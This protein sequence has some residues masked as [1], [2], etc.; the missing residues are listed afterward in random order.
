MKLRK[1]ILIPGL[2]YVSIILTLL[3][4]IIFL[5]DAGRMVIISL[6]TV[7][8]IAIIFGLVYFFFGIFFPLQKIKQKVTALAEAEVISEDNSKSSHEFKEIENAL[9]VHLSRLKEFVQI[10]SNLADGWIEDEFEVKGS[11]DELGNALLKLKESIIK[12]NAETIRRRKMDEQQYWQSQGLTKF[13]ELV[14]D[15]ET[16]IKENSDS[17]I[18][19]LVVFMEME[20]GG[21]F[22]AVRTEEELFLELTGAY[23]FDRNKK[24][25]K[26]FKMGE[27]LVG[28]CA[29]EKETIV[30]T[31]VPED[32]IRIQ[33]GMGDAKPSTIILVPIVFDEQALGV[34]ELASFSYIEKYKI[35]FATSLGKSIAS[36][37]SKIGISSV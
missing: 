12:S 22:L 9:E 8:I 14:R 6:A 36:L 32:Y 37:I 4:L 26:R 28:R 31:D 1:S 20:L 23:A 21:F 15:F 18:R 30:I 27:G 35:D 16:N 13:G 25:E 33:S 17:F 19:E 29:L 3:I 7:I 2:V 10:A 34:I 11:Y 5:S 24:L